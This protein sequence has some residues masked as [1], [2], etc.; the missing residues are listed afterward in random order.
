MMLMIT[1]RLHGAL[2]TLD[3][4]MIHCTEETLWRRCDCCCCLSV[5]FV[6]VVVVVY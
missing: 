4:A 1:H 3:P 2:R 6:V 5:L